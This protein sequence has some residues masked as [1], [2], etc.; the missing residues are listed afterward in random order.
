MSTSPFQMPVLNHLRVASPC[1]VSWDEMSGDNRQRRC[2]HCQMN[3]YNLSEMTREDAES[4][5]RGREGRTCV[6]F[7][8]RA[9][10]TVATKDCPVGLAAVRRKLTLAIS[11]AFTIVLGMLGGA[12]FGKSLSP[13]GTSPGR[14]AW[15]GDSPPPAPPPVMMGRM[16]MGD[17]AMPV[18]QVGPVP[19]PA[20]VS[21]ESTMNHE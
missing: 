3:V 2:Q 20:A 16:V 5:I 1:E 19:K 6:R 8:Q 9:D 13:S 7:Y 10:G 4:F 14:T 17:R 18:S 12:A 21:C 11:A 15:F